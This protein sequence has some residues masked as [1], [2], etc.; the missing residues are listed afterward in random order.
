MFGEGGAKGH[1][2]GDRHSSKDSHY[3]RHDYEDYTPL[4]EEEKKAKTLRDVKLKKDLQQIAC[5]F[6]AFMLIAITIGSIVFYF[7]TK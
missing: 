2:W 6:G 1:T 5:Y 3:P 4:S 7:L